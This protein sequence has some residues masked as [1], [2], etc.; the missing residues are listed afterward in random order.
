MKRNIGRAGK[1]ECVYYINDFQRLVS[2]LTTVG[3][4]SAYTFNSSLLII[5]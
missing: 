1:R 3:L 2:F 4:Y 5:L